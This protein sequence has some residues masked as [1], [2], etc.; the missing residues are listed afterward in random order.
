MI[1]LSQ[2][3]NCVHL[4]LLHWWDHIASNLKKFHEDYY[5]LNPIRIHRELGSDVLFKLLLIGRRC[6][7]G[8]KRNKQKMDIYFPPWHPIFH[9]V[10][11]SDYIIL[12]IHACRN[13]SPIDP[14]L[15]C[16]AACLS[17]ISG[18][19]IKFFSLW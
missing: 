1:S 14:L 17:D 13:P 7:L 6:I 12:E 11:A 5:G 18:Y 10:S 2:L 19:K 8:L 3:V 4:D 9:K 15:Y 16:S